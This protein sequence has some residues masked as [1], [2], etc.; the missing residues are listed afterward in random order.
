MTEVT[1]SSNYFILFKVRMFRFKEV[2]KDTIWGGERILKMKDKPADRNTIGESWEISSLCGYETVVS[3]GPDQGKTLEQLSR[4]YKVDFLGKHV[5]E[6]F[7][8]NFPLLV[9]FI[10]ANRDLSIQVH[11]DDKLAKERHGCNGKSELWYVMDS[12]DEGRLLVGFDH[13]MNIQDYENA[14]EHGDI[15]EKVRSHK[16]KK[17][18]V[19]FLPSGRIHAAC[20]G[21][22]LAEIQQSSD[23]TYRIYDYGRKDKHGNPRELHTEQA[24]AAIDFKS[25]SDYR[26]HYEVQS[27][28]GVEIVKCDYFAT[29]LVTAD[30][31]MEIPISTLDSFC[32]II[33]VEGKVDITQQNG[34]SPGKETLRTGQTILLPA[35]AT[36]ALI[37]PHFASKLLQVW[38][39]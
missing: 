37:K 14:V 4:Q 22:L 23:I 11:P 3:E 38:I 24:K 2:F 8:N 34:I 7:G 1:N 18:D 19:F 28:D 9:K 21:V 10:D 20:A 33:C 17:G 15:A 25:Q 26:T 16:V 5:Y 36:S 6:R 12:T 27:N 39:P 31:E 13:D 35:S 30:N 32:I 29:K